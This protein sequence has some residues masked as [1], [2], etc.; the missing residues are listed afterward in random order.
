MPDLGFNAQCGV[1]KT[2]WRK[3]KDEE[4]D[5]DAELAE[6]PKSVVEMLGFDPLKEADDDEGPHT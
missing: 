3:F 4:L 5:D 1:A 2:D 6:T